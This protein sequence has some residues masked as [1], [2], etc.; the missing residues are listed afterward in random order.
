M[1]YRR[2]LPAGRDRCCQDLPQLRVCI[3]GEK[4][5][6]DFA[7]LEIDT[8]ASQ[9]DPDATTDLAQP[10]NSFIDS[11]LVP[12][13]KQMRMKRSLAEEGRLGRRKAL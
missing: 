1:R 3:H 12:L 5:D 2:L 7:F 9:V 11:K 4:D 8:S 6:I 10:V 13:N